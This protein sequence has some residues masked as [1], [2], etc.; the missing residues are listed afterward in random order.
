M[1]RVKITKL[2]TMKQGGGSYGVQTPPKDNTS[3]PGP[4]SYHGGNT[5]EIKVKNVLQPTDRENANLEAEKGILCN[6]W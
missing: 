6:R 1:K 4:G 2:P 5:P 3:S